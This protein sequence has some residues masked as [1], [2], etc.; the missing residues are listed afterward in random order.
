MA[1]SK[2]PRLA[3]TALAIWWP[4]LS[5]LCCYLIAAYLLGAATASDGLATVILSGI[6][7]LAISSDRVCRFVA[8][9]HH[10][11]AFRR[12]TE[13]GFLYVLGERAPHLLRIDEHQVGE[14]I[15]VRVRR[16]GSIAELE[17]FSANLAAELQCSEVRVSASSEDAGI[18]RLLVV[19]HAILE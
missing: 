6:G 1:D 4:E 10:F 16:G 17:R 2:T 3:A 13:I 14:T 7:A 18:G 19:R 11:M 8:E 9:R 15:S 5:H 12:R